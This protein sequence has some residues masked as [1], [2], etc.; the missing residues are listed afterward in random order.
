MALRTWEE[1]LVTWTGHRLGAQTHVGVTTTCIMYSL[2]VPWHWRYLGA[3]WK[4]RSSGPAPD[5]INPPLNGSSIGR[6]MPRTRE[7]STLF[8]LSPA[9][10]RWPRPFTVFLTRNPLAKA[11]GDGE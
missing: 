9:S 1:S 8:F 6:W 10:E 11:S 5:F 2:P 3:Y 4:G 7:A